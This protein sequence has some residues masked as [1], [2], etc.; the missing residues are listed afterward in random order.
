LK[1]TNGFL[2]DAYTQD[3][4]TL[5]REWRD[6]A[7]RLTYLRGRRELGVTIEQDVIERVS[8]EETNALAR[9]TKAVQEAIR[10][11]E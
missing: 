4:D 1:A 2:Q 5:K 8:A 7:N 11:S 6:A 9:Y 3:T 10:Q